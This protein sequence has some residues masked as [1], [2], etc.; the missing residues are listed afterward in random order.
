MLGFAG[1]GACF[2]LA[3]SRLTR[4]WIVTVLLLAGQVA[5]SAQD[6]RDVPRPTR[7]DDRGGRRDNRMDRQLENLGI[8]L[9]ISHAGDIARLLSGERS[10]TPLPPITARRPGSGAPP[11]GETRFTADEV[12]VEIA[13][14]STRQAIAALAQRNGLAILD[15]L[16]SQLSGTLLLRG[17]ITDQRSVAAVIAALE[18]DPAVFSA[19]PNYLYALQEQAP[20]QKDAPL[21]YAPQKMHLPEAHVLAKGDR[22]LVALLDSG[23]DATQPE[24]K[25][26]I[27]R[28]FDALG[29]AAPPHSHGTAIAGL[30]AAH[31]KLEGSAPAARLLAVRAFAGDGAGAQGSS[32]ALLKGLDW[33]ALQGARVVNMS[34]AGPADPA[35]A[36]ALEAA[37]RNTIVLVAAAGNAGAK[38][39][40]LYPGA[41][42]HVIAVT[43]TDDGDRL[44]A[45]ANRG[46]YIALAAPG[47]DLLVAT[48]ANGYDISSGT[49]LS[50]A[51]VSGI[52]ALMLQRQPNMSPDQV[53]TALLASG[54]ALPGGLRLVNARRALETAK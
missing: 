51:E 43:A 21:Q 54:G 44:F 38:S 2:M 26:S 47:V 39:P 12:V 15:Q 10:L 53:R 35:V 13:A 28:S 23:V 34:F 49:S 11:P 19:Q 50:A 29:G 22:V 30:I 42:P 45:A 6:D 27:A 5:A 1:I 48:P 7:E 25:G 3:R 40:P 41:D 18:A 37:W 46:D 52:I 24:I 31:G 36:R 4:A 9:A 8:G 17:Q 20:G 14:R 16:P 32:F 33:A